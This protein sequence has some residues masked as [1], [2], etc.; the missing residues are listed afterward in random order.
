MKNNFKI[1]LVLTVVCLICGFLLSFVF[2]AAKAKIDE[3]QTKAIY[4]GFSIIASNF[5]TAEEETV[6]TK[7]VYKL[8]DSGHALI[9]YAYLA[10]GQGY[11]GTIKILFA[12]DPQLEKLLGIEIV[13]SVETPGLGS[14]I[15]EESF[16]GQFRNLITSGEIEC[17]KS[18]PE[19]NNEVQAIT[20]AT[21]SSRAVVHIVNKGI[22]ELK[23]I[24]KEEGIR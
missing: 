8:Y 14:R 21:I 15:N 1:I 2:S 23:T 10:E 5:D 13:E 18:V 7:T 4:R 3:N 6:G 17:V 12:L 11:G 9:G 24:L 22:D 16:K 20:S 19:K